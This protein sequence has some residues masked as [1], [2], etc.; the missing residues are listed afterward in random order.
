LWFFPIAARAGDDDK[1]VFGA[2]KSKVFHTHPDE[3]AAAKKINDENMI[4]FA[5]E[6]EARDQGRRLCKI[7]LDLDKKGDL[8]SRVAERDKNKKPRRK[9]SDPPRADKSSVLQHEE[10]QIKRAMPDGTLHL[11]DGQRVCLWGVACP[12]AGQPNHKEAMSL[13]EQRIRGEGLAYGWDGETN[14][15]MRDRFGR[16]RVYILHDDLQKDVAI[17]LLS[18]GLAW[19]DRDTQCGRVEVYLNFEEQAW[20]EGRGVWARL[21]GEAGKRDVLIGRGGWQYHPVGCPHHPLLTAPSKATI[22]EAKAR[23]LSPCDHYKTTGSE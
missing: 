23:R 9:P 17:E 18:K 8:N 22:N 1:E 19:V 3:C 7:C 4:K 5:S 2:K 14:A 6:K 21:E 20:Q 10:V 15:P 12:V 16:L 13:L 11:D